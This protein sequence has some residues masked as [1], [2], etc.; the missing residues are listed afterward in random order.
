MRPSTIQCPD[1][2]RVVVNRYIRR[3]LCQ[4]CYARRWKSGNLDQPAPSKYNLWEVGQRRPDSIGYVRIKTSEGRIR[5]E[6][7]LIM[8]NE[9]GRPLLRTES[10]HHKNGNRSD[11]RLANLELWFRGQ[12]AGQRVSDLIEYVVRNHLKDLLAAID[13][14]VNA[15]I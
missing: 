5:H 13:G 4:P 3:G 8:E 6:H 11:N 2:D 14:D 7:R 1:C 10:V 12:P 15:Y 9:L